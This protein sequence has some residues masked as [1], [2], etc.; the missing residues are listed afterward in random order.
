M[1]CFNITMMEKTGKRSHLIQEKVLAL[2]KL[3]INKT[4][5]ILAVV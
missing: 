2:E 3:G 4:G 5:Y 1:L